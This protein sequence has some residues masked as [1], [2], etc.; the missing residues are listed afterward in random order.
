[1]SWMEKHATWKTDDED[2]GSVESVGITEIKISDDQIDS[3][4]KGP[5]MTKKYK[6]FEALA[7]KSLKKATGKEARVQVG[8]FMQKSECSTPDSPLEG[9]GKKKP[10]M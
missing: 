8:I 3:S 1:M 4:V 2:Y 7:A 9:S 10:P 6:M 5:P